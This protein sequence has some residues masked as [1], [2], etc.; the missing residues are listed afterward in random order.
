MMLDSLRSAD[1]PALL[2]LWRYISAKPR[3]YQVP[4][5]LLLEV[6]SELNFRGLSPRRGHAPAT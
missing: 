3:R 2:R 6:A 4:P 5:S 1:S